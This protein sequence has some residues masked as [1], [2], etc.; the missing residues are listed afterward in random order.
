[1]EEGVI[2]GHMTLPNQQIGL[3]RPLLTSLVLENLDHVG[4]WTDEKAA[5]EAKALPAQDFFCHQ[6][7]FF[8]SRLYH[9][10]MELFARRDE[11]LARGEPEGV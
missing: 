10:L 4:R 5:Y 7:Q 6:R 8:L 2:K 1:L 11:R 9:D 3:T